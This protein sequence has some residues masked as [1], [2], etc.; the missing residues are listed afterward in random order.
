MTSDNGHNE[1]ARTIA[2]TVLLGLAGAGLV[3]FA[4]RSKSGILPTIAATV[5]Y[6]LITKAIS[7]GVLSALAPSRS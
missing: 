3:Y 7:G 6:S 4:R 5:G 1:Q 2:S